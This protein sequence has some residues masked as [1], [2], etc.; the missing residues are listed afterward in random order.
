MNLLILELLPNIFE[1]SLFQRPYLRLAGRPDYRQCRKIVRQSQHISYQLFQCL[2]TNLLILPNYRIYLT[3][4]RR[5]GH[6]ID[7][8]SFGEIKLRNFAGWLLGYGFG[9]KG[10]LG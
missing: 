3:S 5:P 8:F 1:L 9:E 4:S 7:R 2:L 10:A 6:I